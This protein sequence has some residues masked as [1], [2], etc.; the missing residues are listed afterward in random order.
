MS[1]DRRRLRGA[2]RRPLKVRAAGGARRCPR[3]HGR[4][5]AQ[6]GARRARP[7]SSAGPE[8]VDD[9]LPATGWD[10]TVSAC[11]DRELLPTSATRPCF[12]FSGDNGGSTSAGV[13]KDTVK[14]SYRLTADPNLL[15]LLG[16]L[17]GV[18]LDETNE[19][20]LATA[21]A[22]VE[23]FNNTFEFYGRKIEPGLRGPG[24]DPLRVHRR[25]AVTAAATTASRWP[26]RSGSPPT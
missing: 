23:Y 22:L 16:Q 5:R 13:T 25:R 2:E 26:T 8:V 14:V 11:T 18:P 9:G 12:T 15:V 17:G 7:A 6:H 24:P 19:E 20:M 4:H 21:E 1:G 3:R 10:D